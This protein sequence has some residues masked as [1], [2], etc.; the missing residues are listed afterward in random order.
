MDESGIP[1][2]MGRLATG[3]V[4]RSAKDNV[5]RVGA[6]ENKQLAVVSS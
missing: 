6:I 5:T 4:L 2:T 1:G 3:S